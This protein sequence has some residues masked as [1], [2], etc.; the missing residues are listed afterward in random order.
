MVQENYF[1]R[2]QRRKEQIQSAKNEVILL[3]SQLKELQEK[4]EELRA[5]RFNSGDDIHV[6][7]EF[8]DANRAATYKE[9]E[10]RR[11]IE[12]VNAASLLPDEL[13][14]VMSKMNI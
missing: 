10:L 4:R 7:K 14:E 2:E 8:M 6:C 5:K 1:D 12:N 13:D 11:A 9:A 3:E